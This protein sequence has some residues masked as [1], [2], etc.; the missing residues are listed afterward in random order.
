MAQ[1]GDQR[2]GVRALAPGRGHDDVD[3]RGAVCAREP[4]VAAGAGERRVELLD[5]DGAGVLDLVPQAEHG[6]LG[7]ER[8]HCGCAATPGDEQPAR[9]RADVD[10]RDG[11]TC[12]LTV[13]SAVP[14]LAT[15]RHTSASV[16]LKAGRPARAGRARRISAS[17]AP[18]VPSP[19][20][21]SQLPSGRS[22]HEK[23]ADPEQDVEHLGHLGTR[24]LVLDRHEHLEA[25][26]EVARHQ[27]GAAEQVCG[28]FAGLDDECAAVLEPAP[29]H[30]ANTDV[31]AHPLDPG[32]Q[33]AHAA[34]D[35]VDRR[36]CPRRRV[37]PVDDLD[38]GEVVH[39][40][41]DPG[42]L[43][44]AGGIGHRPDMLEQ[45][46]PQRVGR[47]QQLPEGLRPPEPR[48]QVEQVSHVGGD[49]V[50]GREQAEV[51]VQAG[52]DGVIVAGADM[53]IAAQ[54]AALAAD[55]QGRLRVHLEVGEAVRDVRPR[56]F[57]RP[58]PV[59]VAAL[60]EAG[61]EL[62][63]AHAL[64]ALLGGPD[65]RRDQ[66]RALAG[67]VDGRL[68]R[69]RVGIAGTGVDE[70]L[71]SGRERVVGQVDQDVA[72]VDGREHLLAIAA[73]K[74]RR[75]QPHPRL[76]LE[77]GPVEI[78]ELGHVGEVEHAVDAEHLTVADVERVDQPPLHPRRHVVRHLE[79]HDVAEPA[80]AQLDL[81]RLE[82]VVGVVRHLEVGVAGD[83]ERGRLD[84]LHAREEAGQE[85]GDHLLER[86]R[87]PVAA[88]RDEARHP[89][90]APSPAPAAP[91]RSR[92]R[93]RTRPG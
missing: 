29:E 74:P 50:V 3:V 2:L 84:H 93:G 75:R 48:Q 38:V 90:R 78:G 92:D 55:D 82:Q 21:R 14:R 31:L 59:D 85:V 5:R 44:G 16:T 13:G 4:G 87:D 63:D 58:R 73:C 89:L 56:L 26:V 66:R 86:E 67:A 46:R 45:L 20:S 51:L 60:V 25:A 11:H 83:P 18:P 49:V 28:R 6:A 47:D 71:D 12:S 68:Q 17:W 24:R 41:P 64:L 7:A 23:S 32:A 91:P 15:F 40:D 77:V 52:G 19:G 43:A 88:D 37:Q 79:P 27:V 8:D 76:V 36:P 39:L 65:Q 54:A 1:A 70:L 9:V 30:A 72:R 35:D 69:H 81:H 62:D 61:F 80:P 22:C 53:R 42:A 10:H 57:Q 33:R 34:G